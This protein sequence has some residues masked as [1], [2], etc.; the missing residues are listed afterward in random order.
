MIEVRNLSKRHG[1]TLA[2]DRLSFTVR[3][4]RVTAFLGPNGAGKTT[5][6]RM[7]LGL[8]RPDAGQALI[9]G[10]PYAAL[11]EPLRRVGALPAAGGAHRGRRARD[12]VRWLALTHGIPRAR[13]AEVM[14][15]TGAAAFA[16]RRAGA[17]SLG[18][19]QRLGLAAALLGDPEVLVLDEPGNG[20]DPEGIRWL[21]GLLRGLA[22]E[23]RTVLVSSHLMAETAL[24]ADHVLVLAGGRLL[25]DTSTR[26]LAGGGGAAELEE[27]FFRLTASARGGTAPGPGA[28]GGEPA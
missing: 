25:A 24:T 20:L 8:A 12:H 16:R 23:G 28:R 22:A 27:S 6:L 7:I 11:P 3:P 10:R 1:G 5:T 4:G 18:M 15:L 21:R 17:L 19:G 13:V 14:E 9:N 2:V 26:D